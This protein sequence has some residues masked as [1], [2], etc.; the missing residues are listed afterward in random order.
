M[1]DAARTWHGPTVWID[2][3]IDDGDI[4]AAWT[5]APGVATAR[6]QLTRADHL[7]DD[8]PAEALEVYLR[9]IEPLKT[10]TG[11]ATYQEIARL[12]LR[13]RNCHQ[14]LG[15]TAEFETYLAG[16][17]AEQKR[18][19]NLMKILDQHGL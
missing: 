11:D 9:A 17:R 10:V 16:L 1:K 14:H 3:L 13:A 6:Q 4:A 7:A 2:A 18:K 5:A 8:R 12:L 15:T 19:R